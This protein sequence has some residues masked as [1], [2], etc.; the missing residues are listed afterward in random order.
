MVLNRHILG[1]FLALSMTLP[2]A[3]AGQGHGRSVAVS[4]EVRSD[5]AP[6]RP[7]RVVSMNLCTDQLAMML[8]APGQLLSVGHLSTDPRGSAMADQAG[9]YTINHGMAEEIWLMQ[10]DLVIT[11]SF[12]NRATVDMLRRLGVPVAVLEPAYGLS[13]IP[14]RIREVGVALGREEAAE[15]VVR[16]FETRLAA[17]QDDVAHRPRAALYYANGYTSGDKTLA[18]EI[19]ATAGFDNIATEAGFPMGGVMPLEVLALSDPD[20]VISG[21]PYPGASR[22]EEILDHPVVRALREK[23]VGAVLTDRDWICG[24]PHVLRAVEEMRDVRRAMETE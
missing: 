4:G 17:L 15:E 11:G 19:I 16:D 14:D 7:Q 6:E 24:T 22:S 23:S 12:S 20:A 2:G 5:T 8:A 10:P 3:V 1:P 18:G 21:K 9:N 13:D